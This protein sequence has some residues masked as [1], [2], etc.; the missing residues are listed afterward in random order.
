M[1]RCNTNVVGGMALLV[2]VPERGAAIAGAGLETVGGV[3][4]AANL[5][6]P[7]LLNA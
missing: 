4:S 6:E 2:E 3:V 5:V 7:K 1:G